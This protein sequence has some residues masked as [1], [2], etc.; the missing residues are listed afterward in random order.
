MNIK[1][2]NGMDMDAPLTAGA[3]REM[4]ADMARAGGN[5]EGAEALV[6][7]P[8][9]NMAEV[10]EAAG[11]RRDQLEG[12]MNSGVIPTPIHTAENGDRL[13]DDD[14]MDR[15]AKVRDNE[16][17]WS[18]GSTAEEDA[19]YE[20]RQATASIRMKDLSDDL[21]GK[22]YKDARIDRLTKS[23]QFHNLELIRS[24]DNN[25]YITEDQADFLT[26]RVENERM[27]SMA[28]VTSDVPE[29]GEV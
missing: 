25:D 26:S 5:I 21:M 28:S 18:G 19:E 4:L 23:F 3:M 15:I 6:G 16:T 11:I 2:I 24:E 7:K 17:M 29:A 27:F 12:R 14:A 1:T 20:A 9:Y 22:G 8:A 13:W 10:I